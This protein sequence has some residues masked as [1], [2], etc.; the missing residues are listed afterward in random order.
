MEN[1]GRKWSYRVRSRPAG[2]EE[3]IISAS[4]CSQTAV[5]VDS[6]CVPGCGVPGFVPAG[7]VSS[8]STLQIFR[9]A[10]K[11][12]V[13][14]ALPASL[15]ARSFPSTPACRGLYIHRSFRKQSLGNKLQS[16]QTDI[17][18]KSKHIKGSKERY[19]FSTKTQP[20]NCRGNIIPFVKLRNKVP[21]CNLP[22]G[23]APKI[24]T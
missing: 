7:S 6:I 2:L 1:T 9:E 15:S 19:F 21:F 17:V 11:P 23:I 12:L 10:I 14:V 4:N 8:S 13:K 3:S 5:S 20:A 24:A 22:N 18:Q 16:R